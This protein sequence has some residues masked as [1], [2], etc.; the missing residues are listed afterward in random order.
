MFSLEL[1]ND[2]LDLQSIILAAVFIIALIL[3]GTEAEP[4]HKHKAHFVSHGH[5]I[6][7]GHGLLGHNKFGHKFHGHTVVSH[8]HGFG[9]LHG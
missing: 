8:G 1:F 9:F 2:L 7:H 5:F 3:S 6:S 4:K